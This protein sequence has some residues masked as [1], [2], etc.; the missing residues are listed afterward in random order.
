MSGHHSA[1]PAAHLTGDRTF[2]HRHVT[3]V[4]GAGAPYDHG[5]PLVSEF[6]SDR[7]LTWL[8]DQCAGL[9][10]GDR[11][12]HD[13]LTYALGEAAAFRKVSTNFE[14]VLSDAF[15]KP[16]EYD[17]V[18]AYTYWLLG[19]AWNVAHS[20]EM[21][22]TNEYLGLAVMMLDWHQAGRD[23]AVITF[24]YDTS[25]EDA[26]AS[27]SRM[28]RMMTG[29]PDTHLFFNYGFDAPVVDGV[30]SNF[31]NFGTTILP[32]KYPN[33]VVPVLKLHGSINLRICRSCGAV[34]Y[35][36]FEGFSRAWQMEAL[37]VCRRCGASPLGPLLVPPGKRK[38]IPASLAQ[39][40]DNA[41]GQLA[42]S[43]FVVIIGYSMPEYD[44]EAR[45][46]FRA[47]LS[48]KRVLLVDPYPNKDAIE[49]LEKVAKA[50]LQ[51]IPE[52]AST[53]LRREVDA[54]NP[55]IQKLRGRCEPAYLNREDMRGHRR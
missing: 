2:V 10:A 40:W 11:A 14:A 25:M 47:T 33:G 35:F 7:Y 38:E 16:A 22:T 9:P 51:I 29:A 48:N 30:P 39:L 19:S 3:F 32:D 27:A 8:C 50:K 36:A 53:F 49:F 31:L 43:D 26:V 42:S 21:M 1:P 55:T 44:V 23:C 24:N 18:L 34:H 46:L 12:P 15:P 5:F 52:T 54:Y 13:M 6:L 37:D 4:V 45:D 28:L 17:R 41:A 20:S